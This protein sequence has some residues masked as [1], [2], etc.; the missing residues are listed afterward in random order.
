MCEITRAS[1][2][3]GNNLHLD[4]LGQDVEPYASNSNSICKGQCEG[5]LLKNLANWL[6][7]KVCINLENLQQRVER[8]QQSVEKDHTHKRTSSQIENSS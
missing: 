5:I 1:I 7:V 4:W 6:V 2:R 3:D 8:K